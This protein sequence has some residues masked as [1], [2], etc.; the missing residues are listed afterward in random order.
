ML[1]SSIIAK[2]KSISGRGLFTTKNIKAGEVIWKLD[3]NEKQLSKQGLD[4]LPKDEQ[5]LAFQYFDKFIVVHDGSQFMNHSCNPN[6]WWTDND[7]LSASRDINIGEEI[8]YDYST[9]DIGDWI[10]SW[11]CH[12]GSQNCRK[13]ITGH[14]ILD[15]KLAEKYQGN[16]PEWVKEYINKNK[17]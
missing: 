13:K 6:T 8:T 4:N 9:A 12:C 11:N 15:K 17:T 1:C 3:S 16:I 10:A 5:N 14:D 2:N 7:E